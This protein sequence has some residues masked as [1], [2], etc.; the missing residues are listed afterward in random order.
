MLLLEVR[1]NKNVISSETEVLSAFLLH[2]AVFPISSK[3]LIS[4][5]MNTHNSAT[6]FISP[7]SHIRN[8]NPCY[9]LFTLS[10]HF[11]H[12]FSPIFS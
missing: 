2:S 9:D 11:L 6:K 3:F 8:I 4:I 12:F 1:I 7:W 5:N 10:L